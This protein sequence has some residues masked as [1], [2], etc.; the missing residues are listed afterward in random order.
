[1][2]ENVEEL[3]VSAIFLKVER[4]LRPN[5]TLDQVSSIVHV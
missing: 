3:N 1:M 4:S 2:V 5:L